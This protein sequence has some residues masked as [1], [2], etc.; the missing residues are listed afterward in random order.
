M[1]PLHLGS[2]PAPSEK[3]GIIKFVVDEIENVA[4]NYDMEQTQMITRKMV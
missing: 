1:K 4:S 2:R 3:R